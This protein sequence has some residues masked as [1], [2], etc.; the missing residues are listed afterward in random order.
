[1]THDSHTG[2]TCTLFHR[3]PSLEKLEFS[4][5]MLIIASV[6]IVTI[7]ISVTTEGYIVIVVGAMTRCGLRSLL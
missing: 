2:L 3:P 7:V 1:M 4:S 6:V 5:A